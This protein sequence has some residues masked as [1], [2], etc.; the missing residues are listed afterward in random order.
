MDG[1]DKFSVYFPDPKDHEM[2]AKIANYWKDHDLLTGKEQDIQLLSSDG[3]YQL[4]LIAKD[5]KTKTVSLEEK[6]TLSKL[7][8]D[9][10]EKLGDDKTYFEIIICND[11]FE[12]IVNINE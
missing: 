9:L 8:V 5:S 11:Q 1:G 12:P 6:I 10:R 4:L 7:Q 2:A 3:N